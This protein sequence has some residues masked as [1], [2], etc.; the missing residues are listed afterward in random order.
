MVSIESFAFPVLAGLLER[1]V[2]IE[3]GRKRERKK[4]ERM[5][6]QSPE[7][8]EKKDYVEEGKGRRLGEIPYG[9]INI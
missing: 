1:P 3:D 5:T 8:E 4:V 6:F 7:N 2:V 9:K